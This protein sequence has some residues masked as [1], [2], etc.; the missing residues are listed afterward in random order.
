VAADAS[1]DAALLSVALANDGARHR[2]GVWVRRRRRRLM[3]AGEGDEGS[4]GIGGS[5]GSGD[6]GGGGV[7]C[8]S[9]LLGEVICHRF[10]IIY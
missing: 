4:G 9:L 1:F 3:T 7:F 8:F 10:E 6:G 5:G 2:E